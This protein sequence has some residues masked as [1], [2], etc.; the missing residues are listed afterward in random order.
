MLSQ[1]DSPRGQGAS[2]ALVGDIGGTNARFALADLAAGPGAIAAPRTF[3]C[4]QF[5]TAEAAIE[6]YLAETGRPRPHAALIAV[7]GPVSGGEAV[8]T[9]GAW[10]LSASSLED[11][12]FR[13]ARLINDYAALALAAPALEGDDRQAIGRPCPGVAR[14]TVAV[15]GAGTGFG[16][17]ALTWDEGRAIAV[18]S[19]GGHAA[20]APS[21][22][23]EAGL[24]EILRRRF[25]RVS[26]ERLLSG[27]GLCNLY[28]ALTE[29]E[30]APTAPPT[31]AE[32]TAL[33]MSGEDHWAVQTLERF[34]AIFGSVAGDIALT[35]GAR[36]GVY[37]AGGIAPRILPALQASQFRKRFEAKG[38]FEGYMRQIPTHVILQPHAA[39]IGA[40]E[41]LRR[42]RLREDAASLLPQVGSRP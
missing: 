40:A 41:Q 37:L 5:E 10:R 26:I 23:V 42:L 21:D 11:R 22:E 13:Y 16:V 31:P 34:C 39:L 7:A 20:F 8:F 35:L 28:A 38:R 24:L 18:S 1:Y 14:E 4:Q 36:G 32:I 29:L 30:G 3:L 9:N 25:G 2:L 33:A 17:S 27:P 15:I 19:E 12:G 6:R